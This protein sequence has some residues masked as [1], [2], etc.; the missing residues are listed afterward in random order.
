MDWELILRFRRAGA[1]FHRLPYFLGAFRITDTQKTSQLLAST[2]LQE[3]NRLRRQELG[4][5]PSHEEVQ[6]RMK[7]Y[8]RRHWWADKW[9]HLREK[10]SLRKDS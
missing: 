5:V 10:I 8:V 7:S 1:R 6:R 9:L 4:Y 2:G 3:S